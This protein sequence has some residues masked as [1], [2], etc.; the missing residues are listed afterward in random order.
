MIAS[1]PR[2]R[3]ET[4]THVQSIPFVVKPLLHALQ[5]GPAPTDIV[6]LKN[7]ISDATEHLGR[8]ARENC[9]F[10]ALDVYLQ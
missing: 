8:R 6:I 2:S 4:L 10:S 1:R 7:E 3:Y 9:I 5:L